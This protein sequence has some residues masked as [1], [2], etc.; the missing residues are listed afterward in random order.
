M[1]PRKELKGK[2][3]C[4]NATREFIFIPQAHVYFLFGSCSVIVTENLLFFAQCNRKFI[5]WNNFGVMTILIA[6]S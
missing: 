3:T 6:I 4:R 2:Q 1:V 5:K